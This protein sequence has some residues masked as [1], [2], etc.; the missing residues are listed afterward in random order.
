M[1]SRS[2]L[3]CT[4]FP[5]LVVVAFPSGLDAGPTARRWAKCVGV[6]D[7]AWAT[8]SSLSTRCPGAV[9]TLAVGHRPRANRSKRRVREQKK[10]VKSAKSH[11]SGA[12]CAPQSKARA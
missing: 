9:H 1:P 4:P 2:S 10:P 3:C 6:R 11:A 5:T 7:I 12:L 8:V